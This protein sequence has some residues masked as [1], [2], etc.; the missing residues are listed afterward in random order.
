MERFKDFVIL[1]LLASA[2]FLCFRPWAQPEVRDHS[3][4]DYVAQVIADGGVPYRDAVEIKTPASAYMGAAAILAGRVV[5]LPDFAS[6]RVLFF[7]IS[8]G[9][10]LVVYELGALVFDRGTG[11][12]AA[13]ITTGVDPLAE[14]AGAGI[15][16]KVPFVLFGLL[17]ICLS[18]RSRP[19]AAGIAA[20]LSALCWQ[21][22][23]IF[24]L[25]A[26]IPFIPDVRK[27]TRLASGFC[28]PVAA[29]ALYFL[30]VGAFDDL[31]N[32][33]V[34][35]PFGPYVA[36]YTRSF[37]GL[38]GTAWK[39]LEQ[40]YAREVIFLPIAGCGLL[41]GI[42]L[43]VRR[44]K[45]DRAPRWRPLLAAATPIA[46]M[47]GLTALNLQGESDL[48]PIFPLAFPFAA[49]AI[50]SVLRLA[51]SHTVALV[52]AS[53]LCFAW[54]GSDALTYRLPSTLRHQFDA[55]AP[56]ASLVKPGDRVYAH[57][58]L[59][60]LVLFNLHNAS[61]HLFLDR[62]KDVFIEKLEPDGFK[63]FLVRLEA[64]EPK[65]VVLGRKGLVE[66]DD[67][68]LAWIR[69]RYTVARRILL[70]YGR[71]G[72]FGYGLRVYVRKG[73]ELPP[74]WGPVRTDDFTSGEE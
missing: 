46:V 30:F 32:W 70:R 54:N 28:A 44:R 68:L 2:M 42:A 47:L 21:P 51:L 9:V 24:L 14:W 4:W 39:L 6:I 65:V 8:V 10:V 53:I 62:G 12:L 16:P 74:D 43:A 50:L 41:I 45:T 67:E 29:C 52:A 58:D 64:A 73:T 20:G 1:S 71:D 36:K 23:C 66:R 7:L 26:C 61:P 35:F 72:R 27:L 3:I 33:T 11:L 59:Q 5:G 69:D 25:P 55:L 31:W 38:T 48:F 40:S 49:F 17:S 60:F 34:V 13:V 15:Q 18:L 22:G 63:K 56:V 19:L 57:G 37:R